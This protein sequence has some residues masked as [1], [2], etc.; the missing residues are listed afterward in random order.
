MSK[1]AKE[2]KITDKRMFTADGELREEYRF[3][4]EKSTT[5]APA[6]A[7]STPAATPAVP[8]A[9]TPA[10]TAAERA[11]QAPAASPRGEASQPPPGRLRQGAPCAPRL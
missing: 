5:A 9:A 8:A 2:I 11:D 3:L 10:A 4:A 7:A 1:D 6:D